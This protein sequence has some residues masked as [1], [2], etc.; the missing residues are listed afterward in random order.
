MTNAGQFGMFLKQLKS[1]MLPGAFFILLL[2]ESRG[3]ANFSARLAHKVTLQYESVLVEVTVKNETGD[4]MNIGPG[5][6]GLLSFVIE[7]KPGYPVKEFKGARPISGATVDPFSSRTFSIN[8]S[9]SYDLR[10]TG[11]YN[12]VARLQ[13]DETILR[14]SRMLLEVVPGFVL[15][16]LKAR[17]EGGRERREYTLRTL[18]RGRG[19]ELFLRIE[20][21]EHK[22]CYGVY[23][24]G[25]LVQ[26][27]QP[28]MMTD[29]VGELHILHLA[30]PSRFT[31]TIS[32]A[33]GNSIKQSYISREGAP[34]R[35]VRVEGGRVAVVGG[36]E[37]QGDVRV[38]RPEI[39]VFDPFSTEY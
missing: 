14:S 28:A 22:L 6:T 13:T 31:H 19:H 20:D 5:G 3:E 27:E 32:A 38:A 17:I 30:S 34:A 37:Y 33:S 1:W 21:R 36:S 10:K 8:V 7:R 12:L 16:S 4:T 24:L 11:P 18:L 29:R 15:K 23:N 25:R 9:R 35:L 26:S 2:V 39:L